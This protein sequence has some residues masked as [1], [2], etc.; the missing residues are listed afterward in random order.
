MKYD[1]FLQNNA[2]ELSQKGGNMTSFYMNQNPVQQVQPSF[3]SEPSSIAP[4]E[5]ESTLQGGHET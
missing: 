4:N 5:D 1:Q 3:L 2:R